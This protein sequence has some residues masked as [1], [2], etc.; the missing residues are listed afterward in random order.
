MFNSAVAT[1]NAPPVSIVLNW[2]SSYDGA[3]GPLIDM[4]QAVP[5]YSAHPDILGALAKGASDP[6]LARYGPVEGDPEFRNA[7]ADH[8]SQ[9]YNAKIDCSEVQITSGCNQA[10]VATVLALAGHGDRILMM[11]PCY[12][13]HESTLGMLGVGIDYIDCDDGGGLLPNCALIDAAI[14]P[15]TRAI[16]LV[17]P[18][19]PAGSIYPAPLLADILALCQKRGIWLI[20]DETYRDFMPLDMDVPHHL[21]ARDS[22]QSSL[23]QLYSFSKSYCLPG[24]RLGAIVAG[25]NVIAQLAKVIDNIQI[26][27]PRVAQHALTPMLASMTSW[28]QENRERIAARATVFRTAMDDLPGWDLLSSGAYFGYVRHPFTGFGSRQVAETMACKAGVLVI[29][30]AFFGAGQD[31]ALRFA[32]ANAGRDVIAKLAGRLSSLTL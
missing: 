30:G 29:P 21:F 22:W 12:F 11:R 26:C 4:S 25:C 9:I 8:V 19:N 17:S 15:E 32:F 13:N 16:A 28:R 20:L 14:G 10:F 7:Y 18:N 31:G 24:H 27:A 2:K 5:G 6:A 1:L 23:I 3:N